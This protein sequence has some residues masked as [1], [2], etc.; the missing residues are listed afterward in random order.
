MSLAMTRE[1]EMPFWKRLL[2]FYLVLLLIF[3]TAVPL[4]MIVLYWE[5]DFSLS[6]LPVLI[7]FA[8]QGGLMVFL[9]ALFEWR[10][11]R[12]RMVND[13][14]TLR[15]FLAAMLDHALYR[16]QGNVGVDPTEP[17]TL[18]LKI[19]NAKDLDVDAVKSIQSMI[20]RRKDTMNQMAAVA[21]QIDFE[22]LELWL[23]ITD[24]MQALVMTEDE[25]QAAQAVM[26]LVTVLH[27]FDEL[28]ID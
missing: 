21:A 24:I 3:L 23:A 15:H 5:T 6:I 26:E 13:K 1:V 20:K 7:S 25:E 10:S 8:L 9:F 4:L 12:Q 14:L 17:V 2:S 18:D 16:A 11:T 27:Q 19:A 28:E 22:H